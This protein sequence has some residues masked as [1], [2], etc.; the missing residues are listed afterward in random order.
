MRTECSCYSTLR[1]LYYDQGCS[2]SGCFMSIQSNPKYHFDKLLVAKQ[3]NF[4][5]LIVLSGRWMVASRDWFLPVNINTI[6]WI[7]SIALSGPRRFISGDATIILLVSDQRLWLDWIGNQP[8]HCSFMPWSEAVVQLQTQMQQV[9]YPLD[10]LHL[11]LKLY[12]SIASQQ[13]AAMGG[14]IPYP[15]Q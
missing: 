7:M 15:I 2:T 1:G 6:L 4:F 9:G 14:L 3:A 5:S 8:T 11:G 12:N 13:E 10:W